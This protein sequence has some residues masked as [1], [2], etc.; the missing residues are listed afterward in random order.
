MVFGAGGASTLGYLIRNHPLYWY[1]DGSGG[2]YGQFLRFV[3][4]GWG[5]V[6]V[7]CKVPFPQRAA[8]WGELQGS[9]RAEI[10]ALLQL[11]ERTLGDL[12]V[13]TDCDYL[14]RCFHKRW[15]ARKGCFKN[16]DLWCRIGTA[17]NRRR[18][19][20]VYKV[21]AHVLAPDSPLELAAHT[22][23]SVVGNELADAFAEE[24][25]VLHEV[26]IDVVRAVSEADFLAVR[27]QKQ[28]YTTAIQ[29]VPELKGS[30][31][32]PGSRGARRL[33]LRAN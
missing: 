25:A 3:R 2:I 33:T 32:A 8:A 14:V 19:V 23:T 6:G 18:K 20:I 17:L 26:P 11:M 4:A 29:A 21:K 12:V 7:S 22:W 10:L 27:I 13:G 30:A 5:A 16:G 28:L 1:T 15:W 9:D 24:G 31:K